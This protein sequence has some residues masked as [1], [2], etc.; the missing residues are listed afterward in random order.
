MRKTKSNFKRWTSTL[1][2]SLL[3]VSTMLPTSLIP[4]AKAA[5]AEKV[6]ISQ[7]YGGGGNSGAPYKN[8]FIE[9]YNPTDQ[10]VSLDGWS[11]QYASAAG[12]TWSATN[13]EGTIKAHSYYL[14]EEA[15]GNGDVALLP[16]P[17][18]S[19]ALAIA[20]TAGNVALVSS[21]TLLTSATLSNAI[22]L[23]G[24]GSTAK[25]FEGTGPTVAPSNTKSVQRIPYSGFAPTEAGKPG[26]GNGW[27]TNDNKADFVAV[28]PFPHNSASPAEKFEINESVQPIGERIQFTQVGSDVTIT[29]AAGTVLESANVDIYESATSIGG[30]ALS[31]VTA[32]ADGSFQ[33]SFTSATPLSTV[34]I[35]SIETDKPESK[36]T[37]IDVASPSAN[38]DAALL[39]YNVDGEG[40]GTLI[41]N[42]L[43]ATPGAAVY[44]FS[45]E[46]GTLLPNTLG[47]VQVDGKGAFT[48]KMADA[49]DTVYV[50]QQTT[51]ARGIKLP[52]VPVA[53]T[54]ADT[55]VVTA[56]ADMR[57]SD[58]NGKPLHLNEFYSIE[59]IV[60]F[61][62]GVLGT[63]KSNFYIQD[64]TAA[65]NIFGNGLDHKLSIVRGTKV[66]VTG[67]VI[68]Y[69][70]LTEF[71]PSEIKIISANQELPTVKE[72]SILDMNTYEIIE[73]LE[74][75]LA[76]VS[77]KVS[78]VSA[79]S[80]GGYNV[81]ILDDNNKA[82]TVRVMEKT[83]IDINTA[84]V[85]GKSNTFTGVLSQYSTSV[86]PKN[87]YQL[88]VREAADITSVFDLAHEAITSAY[89]NANIEFVAFADVADSLKLYV[90]ATEETVYTEYAMTS[91]GNG[92]YTY[93]LLA[94]NVPQAGFD[95]YIKATSGDKTKET[96]VQAVSLISDEVGPILSGEKPQNTTRVETPRPEISIFMEDPSGVNVNSVELWLDNERVTT[97][98]I[99]S[100]QVTFTPTQDLTEEIHTVKVVAED[101]KGNVTTK[102]WSF[103]VVPRFTG[104]GHYRGTT[105]NHTNISHDGSGTPEDALKAGLKYGYDFFAFSDHSHDIDPELVGTDTV[106]RDGLPERTGGADW[107]QTKTLADTYT[108]DGEYV[109]FPAFE[110]TSTTWG[111]A[112]VFGTENFIDRNVNGKMYQ[113]LSQY[114]AWVVSYDDVVAQF[115][116]PD[117]SA[118]AFNNFKPYD[119]NVDQ[120]FTMLEV[121]NGSGNYA[122]AN[123]EKKYFS[124][125]DLGW[126]LAPTYG[127]DNHDGTWGKT[128]ARTVIVA[129]DLSQASLLHA[130]RNMRVYMSEDP[131]FELDVMANGYYMGSTVDSNSL[132]FEIS[133]QDLVAES[134]TNGYDYLPTSYTSNDE[135]AKVEIV[136]NGGV[137]TETY[138][139]NTKDFTWEPSITV[140][141]GQQWFVVRV[142]QKDGERTYS[143]PIWSKEVSVDVKVNAID[144]TGDVIIEGNPAT[145]N[146]TVGNFGTQEVKNLKVDFYL[147]EKKESNLI[148]TSTI[149]SIPSKGTGVASTTWALPTKGSHNIIAVVTSNDGL[150]LGDVTFTLPVLVKEPLGIKV[151]IDAAHGNENSSGD[152]GSYKDNLKAFTLLLQKEGYTV[153]ENKA[154]ITDATFTGVNVFMLTHPKTSLT[155]DEQAAVAKFVKAGGSL[156][157]AGKSNN[158]TDPMINNGILA[159]IGTDIR[160][161]SDGVFDDSKSGNFWSDPLVSKFAVRP[162]PELVDNYITDRVPYLDYYSGAS[163]AGP[164]NTALTENEKRIILVKGN[165]TTY[166][167]NLKNGSYVYDIV[168]DEQGGSAIPLIAS[169]EIGQNGRVIVSGMNIFNDK[170]MDESFEPKGNV[171]MS[172]NIVNWLAHRETKV[173]PIDQARTLPENSSVVIEGTV[174]SGAGVFFDAFYLQDETGGVM[175]FNEVPAGSLKLGDKVRIYGH[176]ITFDNNVEIEFSSFDIDVIKTGV[177]A[178]ISPKVVDTGDATKAENQGSLVKVTG[179]VI[180]KFDDNSYVINDGSGDVLVFTDGYIAL[181]SGPVPQ[182]A[183]GDTLEAVG[184]SGGFAGGTRIRVRDTKEL[185]GTVNEI[186]DVKTL[187]VNN[188]T[189]ALEVGASEQLVVTETTTKADETSTDE[190]VTAKATYTGYDTDVIS[191]NAG[192]ITAKA[193]GTTN[194]T[195]T[196]GDNTQT[197]SVTITA[198]PVP[199]VKTLAV[200]KSAVSVQVGATEQ[201][202]VTETTTKADETSTDEDVTAT[203]TYTGYDTNV[204]SVNAGLITAKAA[205]TTVITVTVGDNTQTVSVAVTEVPVVADVKTLA[206]NKTNVQFMYGNSETLVVTETTTKADQSKTQADVT[207]TATYSGYNTSI[208]NV[209]KGVITSTGVGSTE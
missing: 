80:G 84:V 163:L 48:Y 109:V 59:G 26:L 44:A 111:H 158:S 177:G 61:E 168:S 201:L 67:K 81:T 30:T 191:V 120:L 114:Y 69:N 90:K 98:T 77:G 152:G 87:G 199:D 197:V 209:N 15:A 135:V 173:T 3:L 88:F 127:E 86:N 140:P 200:N 174:T 144:V 156:L 36:G 39:S 20:G 166:Q 133:G 187:K 73:P 1:L 118:N 22:D 92:R 141:N 68:Q 138:T 97:A 24:F 17:D 79:L 142:T 70:G 160:I 14:V 76:K 182:L 115:N 119:Q 189:V 146:A 5:I 66:R 16:T 105:H 143:A 35:T 54:K 60:T 190:D 131:N 204:I 147:D 49:P 101:T 192:L 38:V 172:L 103:E 57:G 72:V 150:S 169:E 62:N 40:T 186:P 32:A 104:G 19:G 78:A 94:A 134:R 95:Y 167:G 154:A 28:A 4:H 116:H 63:Q 132:Q 195:V 13:L 175:A 31:E 25:A 106:M 52:S 145:L 34:Y 33:A 12:T 205:G 45:D 8:D 128:N 198:V 130:M 41:G 89:L 170:Q 93:N 159:D 208:I 126:H 183:V 83:K 2:A 74:G 96:A 7:V 165:E 123:A 137:V 56:I 171:Q 21:T 180:S 10:D 37:A 202:T 179:K 11:V 164:N 184:L 153:T 29:A 75:S 181:Q 124:T 125:L 64:D 110:M 9:L 139:P 53:I 194:I 50:S 108:K 207:A 102:E 23:V 58:A 176:M 71:E 100:A 149:S 193:V 42:A 113:D 65:I 129:D 51:S 18:A 178:A 151:L 162:H 148:G 43:A 188:S 117:M 47:D 122:Y 85:T 99:T 55:T 27:D 185:V 206:V 203:A 136:T 121:G 82:T 6:V 91:D 112:N 155:V 107:N 157:V 46:L 196:V 161:Q